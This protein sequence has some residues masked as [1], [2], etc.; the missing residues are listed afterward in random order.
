MNNYYVVLSMTRVNDT[1]LRNIAKTMC[2]LYDGSLL[3]LNARNMNLPSCFSITGSVEHII[4]VNTNIYIC[5]NINYFE[6]ISITTCPWD[7]PLNCYLQL[8]INFVN[9]SYLHFLLH[10]MLDKLHK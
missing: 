7:L 6:N 10:K 8:V 1:E 3:S 9:I 4:S 5:E 2:S